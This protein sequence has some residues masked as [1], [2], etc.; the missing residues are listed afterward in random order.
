MKKIVIFGCSGRGKEILFCLDYNKY[1]VVG[2]VDNNQKVHN[3][4][5]F[6]GYQ[7]KSPNDIN[8]WEFDYVLISI[9]EYF[10][11]IEKQLSSIGVSKDKLLVY[12]PILP[13][14]RMDNRIAFLRSCV[15]R[16]NELNIQG[17]CAEVGVYK[18]EFAKHINKFLPDRKMYLFDTFEGFGDQKLV[19][20]EKSIDNINTAFIDTSVNEVISKMTTPQNCIVR[21][22]YFQETI[23][24]IENQQFAF[25]SLDADLYDPIYEGLVYFY[26]RMSKGGYIFV[27]DYGM[28]AWPGVKQ[29]V[30]RFCKEQ[31]VSIIPLLD[32]CLSCVIVK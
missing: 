9:P 12:N 24:G 8:Q 22:G 21:K 19:E 31:G 18:G 11:S 2:F 14:T 13:V 30:D 6:G 26:P 1:E 32:M 15:E 29:A 7:V 3:S 20:I 10:E 25:V 27:H 5:I 23:E 4:K 17:A 28:A 16:I